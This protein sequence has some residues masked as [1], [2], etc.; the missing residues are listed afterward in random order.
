[1]KKYSLALMLLGFAAWLGG[2][3]YGQTVVVVTSGQISVG[4]EVHFR[5]DHEGGG[6]AS[7]YSW[8]YGD[9]ASETTGNNQAHHAYTAAGTYTVTCMFTNMGGPARERDGHGHG[10]GQP[11]HL[12]AGRRLS[13][14]A[15][16]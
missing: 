5:F 16:G 12:S 3:L 13:A 1:M 14:R 8:S 7:S 15:G 9:G 4:T 6:G 11:P 10:R 2:L